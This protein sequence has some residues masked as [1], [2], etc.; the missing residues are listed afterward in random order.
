MNSTL[1]DPLITIWSSVWEWCGVNLYCIGENILIKLV[2]TKDLLLG[3]VEG[4]ATMVL[5]I[6]QPEYTKHAACQ[7]IDIQTNQIAIQ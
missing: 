7:M 2:L 3:L 6:R 5:Y 1:G 4:I